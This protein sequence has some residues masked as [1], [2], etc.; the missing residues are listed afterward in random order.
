MSQITC[1]DYREGIC[2]LFC[3]G[4][5]NECREKQIVN[6]YSQ[7]VIRLESMAELAENVLNNQND[8]YKM[9]DSMRNTVNVL[10][11]MKKSAKIRNKMH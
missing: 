2:N 11:S 7:T 5:R 6:Q 1:Q 8:C 3:D 9:I 4:T 10:N